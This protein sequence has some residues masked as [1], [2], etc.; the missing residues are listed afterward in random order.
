MV[1]KLKWPAGY[2]GWRGNRRSCFLIIFSTVI[3]NVSDAKSKSTPEFN[4]QMTMDMGERWKWDKSPRKSNGNRN[5]VCTTETDLWTPLN[6]K[7]APLWRSLYWKR[8]KTAAGNVFSRKRTWF[9]FSPIQIS[10]YFFSLPLSPVDSSGLEAISSPSKTQLMSN[11]AWPLFGK[12]HFGS[13][14]S[15]EK[16]ERKKNGK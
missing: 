3:V 9:N 12:E 16:K 5:A 6:P 15:P 13:I 7:I 10:C 14:V 4:F 2:G 11:F 1:P 8:K